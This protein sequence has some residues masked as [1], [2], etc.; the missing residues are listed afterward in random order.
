[1][2]SPNPNR[3]VSL[4][5]ILLLIIGGL[6]SIDVFLARLESSE[7]MSQARGYFKEGERLM[8]GDRPTPARDLFRKAYALDRA[9]QA[10]AL[11]LAD[12]LVE[13]GKWDDAQRMVTEILERSPNDGETNLIEARLLTREDKFTESAA[14]Y[15]RAIFGIWT[16]DPQIRKVAVRLELAHML[17]SRGSQKDLLAELLPL[18]SDAGA[19][20]PVRKQLARLYVTAGSPSRAQAV[21]RALIHEGNTDS[22]TYS[23]LGDAEL[24]LGD[25]RAAQIAFD[26]AS[27]HGATAELQP[28][29]ELATK[30]AALDPT[31]RRLG[32]IEKFERCVRVLQLAR[33]SL[34]AC[35]RG[36]NAAELLSSTDKM[37]AQKKA[38]NVNNE[39]AEERLSM[40]ERLWAARIQACGPSTLAEEEPLRLIMGK[41]TQ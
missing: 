8:N 27:K 11:H 17:A 31:L 37:L 7:L 41:L 38:R 21:Y 26:E 6:W 29:V 22:E 18:E 28:R 5:A 19:D 20:L 2:N 24:A 35:A 32:S 10:Y 33:D 30:M 9:N 15:H 34:A 13:T 3:P 23:G 14:Y 39:L 4:V 1:M 40:A 16:A 25:Y 36:G 12:A